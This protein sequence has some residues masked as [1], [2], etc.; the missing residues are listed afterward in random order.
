MEGLVGWEIGGGEILSNIK[1][2][3]LPAELNSAINNLKESEVSEEAG[4]EL[5]NMFEKYENIGDFRSDTLSD[6]NAGLNTIASGIRVV[7]SILSLFG[8]QPIDR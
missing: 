3:E 1:S 6:I 4:R 7:T 8:A 2:S 5:F